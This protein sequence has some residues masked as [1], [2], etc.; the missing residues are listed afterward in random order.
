MAM[1]TATETLTV[2]ITGIRIRMPHLITKSPPG[3]GRLTIHRIVGY[4]TG[5]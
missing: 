4:V 1:F 3:I 5:F 2:T